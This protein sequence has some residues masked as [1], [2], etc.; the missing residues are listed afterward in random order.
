[1]GVSPSCRTDSSPLRQADEL[2]GLLTGKAIGAPLSP[3]GLVSC[4]RRGGVPQFPGYSVFDAAI[5]VANLQRVYQSGWQNFHAS[6]VKPVARI[7]RAQTRVPGCA[8][9]HA[10]F[11]ARFPAAM[12]P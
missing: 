12:Q 4:N 8:P 9:S 7:N 11:A 6:R 1:M 2:A 5:G 10:K 3:A